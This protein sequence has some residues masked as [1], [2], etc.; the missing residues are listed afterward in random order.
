MVLLDF[1]IRH[2]I[3]TAD[4]EKNYADILP[5]L[6]RRLPFSTV[7]PRIEKIGRTGI[8]AYEKSA[9]GDTT[10]RSK[11][12]DSLLAEG[13]PAAKKQRKSPRLG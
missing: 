10:A 8:E 4:N 1:L 11:R 12:T 3:I 9:S 6:H 5:R 7:I 13:V 2:G